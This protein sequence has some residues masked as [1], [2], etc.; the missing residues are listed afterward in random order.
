MIRRAVF[1]SIFLLMAVGH[2]L[3]SS[4]LDRV[5]IHGRLS[6]R[7]HQI[8]P[9]IPAA[10]APLA[11]GEFKGVAADF[12]TIEAASAIGKYLMQPG[13]KMKDLPPQAWGVIF[14]LFETSQVL[15]PYFSDNYK[16][17]QPFFTWMARWPEQTISFLKKG[18]ARRYWDWEL[19]FFIGFDYFYFLDDKL[20]ASFYFQEAYS[21]PG[22]GGSLT[23]A[24]LSAKLLQKA[25]K[26][27]TAITY[28]V[29]L[30]KKETGDMHRIAFES[31]LLDL[32]GTLIVEKA[33]S[34]YKEKFGYL[35][36]DVNDLLESGILK[37]LP[38]KS[39][40][41]I[42]YCIDQ[43]GNVFFDKPDCRTPSD[44]VNKRK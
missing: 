38:D 29:D 37:F 30:L 9:I 34:A 15:D 14:E 27:E 5:R 6:D 28:L 25:G 17:V 35:P 1:F 7:L 13:V 12:V 22:G 23:L 4:R 8:K 43:I 11:V 2:V 24:T 39:S 44:G 32:K 26:T 42:P 40:S 20:Q 41:A 18:L 33:V 3:I 10:L 31:R 19:A 36:S 16:F 21:R